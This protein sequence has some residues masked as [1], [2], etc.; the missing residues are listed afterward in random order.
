MQN[1]QRRNILQMMNTISPEEGVLTF[2]YI[3][4]AIII[5]WN[6]FFIIFKIFQFIFTV[7]Y[8]KK[9]TSK[10]NK[11]KRSSL[12]FWK[13]LTTWGNIT[14]F[15][16]NKNDTKIPVKEPSIKQKNTTFL[17]TT[18]LDD[19]NKVLHTPR[20]IDNKLISDYNKI[21]KMTFNLP[22]INVKPDCSYKLKY[23]GIFNI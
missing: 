15:F 10:I 16:Q 14:D 6:C 21:K 12:P 22:K 4:I 17:E 9:S 5:L 7:N 19:T 23:D 20:C 11:Y 18:C 13:K 3:V 1:M 8:I 2:P